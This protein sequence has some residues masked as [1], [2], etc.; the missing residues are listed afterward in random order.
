M[1]HGHPVSAP[2]SRRWT[3]D[4]AAAVDQAISLATHYSHFEVCF[5]AF[6]KD[7]HAA[8]VLTPTLVRFTAPGAER[9]RQVSAYQKGLRPHEG[10]F[11]HQR[12]ERQL[13]TPRVP[14]P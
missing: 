2:L 12:P 6:H 10:T 3:A 5:Q 13:Q 11:A 1:K 7:R 9:N 8:E 14:R 4:L